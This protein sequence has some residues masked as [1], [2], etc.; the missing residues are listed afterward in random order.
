MLPFPHAGEV[1]GSGMK[2]ESHG[3]LPQTTSPT[4]WPTSLKR[5]MCF[6]PIRAPSPRKTAIPRLLSTRAHTES[7]KCAFFFLF[8][9]LFWLLRDSLRPRW[10]VRRSLGLDPA[11]SSL[12]CSLLGW[13]HT[14]DS[15][16]PDRKTSWVP[17]VQGLHP[18]D[19]LLSS[20][21]SFSWMDS[22]PVSQWAKPNLSHSVFRRC[23]RVNHSGISLHCQ[24]FTT[25]R[26]QITGNV[27]GASSPQK[28][29]SEPLYAFRG[30]I[31]AF[32]KQ[33][34]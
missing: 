2:S 13:E 10:Q 32:N 15:P 19:L 14:S 12:E 24:R 20:T 33:L 1:L 23:R 25:A 28:V 26:F 30:V 3:T 9:Y 18:E 7:K 29:F 21:C 34:V 22:S 17:G 4:K 31:F 16:F 8:I 11:A 5:R 27:L 6:T